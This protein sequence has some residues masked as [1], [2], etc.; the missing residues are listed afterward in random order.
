MTNSCDVAA[1][2]GAHDDI[3]IL[4]HL[5]P[6]GDALG[7]SLALLLALEACGKRAFVCCQ[8]PCPVYL[9]ML[10]TEGRLFLPEEIP[11]EPRALVCVDLNDASRLGRAAALL[12]DSKSVLGV[13]HHEHPKLQAELLWDC[14]E[15]AAS[16]ELIYQVVRALGASLTQEMALC[17]YAA[18]STDTGNFAFSCTTPACIRIVA[19]CVQTGIDLDDLNYE[20]FRKRS[21]A[22]T[23]LLG[24]ALGDLEYLEAGKIALIRLHPDDFD[25]CG[26][27]QADTEGI[28]NYGINTDGVA[29]AVL[30]VDR[31]GSTKFSLRSRG[32]VN[33]A[34]LLR[35]MGGGG[36]ERAAGITLEGDFDV[37]LERV[38]QAVKS[39]VNA[40]G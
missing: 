12:D 22:R 32:A 3:A 18:I 35:P 21:Q 5:Q 9:N 16:G 29:V 10:P 2:L 6:D 14:P 20:L 4:T 23:K 31:G 30:A 25:A 26:A 39:A 13:D 36:H 17:L 33:L 34:D 37:C 38:M 40:I 28:V 15:A 1:W 7:S 24:R 27:T 11:F 8:D 19:E